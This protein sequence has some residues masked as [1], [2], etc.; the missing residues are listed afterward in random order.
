MG[1]VT[2]GI[3]C[4]IVLLVAGIWYSPILQRKAY[5]SLGLLTGVII[6][7]FYGYHMYRSL[8]KALDYDKDTAT[9][10]VTKD[11]LIRYGAL[12]LILAGLMLVDIVSPL[13]AFLGIMCLKAGAYLQ[14]LMYKITVIFIGEEPVTESM[15]IPDDNNIHSNN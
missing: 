8:D 3:I 12:V 4:E 14:P 11:S 2:F 6:A 10:L 7:V 15:P 9:K 13:T 1:I 5:Y